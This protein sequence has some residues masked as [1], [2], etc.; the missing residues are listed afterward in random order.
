MTCSQFPSTTLR[1]REHLG[2]DVTVAVSMDDAVKLLKGQKFDVLIVD[3]RLPREDNGELRDFGGIELLSDLH[4]A[5]PDAI[6]ARTP[7]ILLTA[8]M[9]SLSGG[10]IIADSRCL[11]VVKKLRQREVKSLVGGYLDTRSRPRG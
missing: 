3:V 4:L 10:G 6:N 9:R 8:Q 5:G 1:L 2:V 7:Y 11:G